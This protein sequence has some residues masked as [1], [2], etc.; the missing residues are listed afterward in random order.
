VLV[1]FAL[2]VPG[3]VQVAVFD[4]LGSQIRQLATGYWPAGTHHL[5][6]DGCDDQ[7]HAVASGTYLA[8]MALGPHRQTVRLT[9]AR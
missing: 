4:A 1:P 3:Q 2:H 8:R 6:W 5:T 9:L 7:G